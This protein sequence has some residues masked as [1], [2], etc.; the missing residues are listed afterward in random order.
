MPIDERDDEIARRE[1]EHAV[2]NEGAR[3]GRPG[4]N[5]ACAGK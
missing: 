3:G 2:G 5:R 4:Y 1:A